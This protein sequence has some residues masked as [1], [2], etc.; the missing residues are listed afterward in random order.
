MIPEALPRISRR[1][2]L[3]SS[4]VG[5]GSLALASLVN[6]KSSAADVSNPLAITVPHIVPRAKRIIFLF[7]SANPR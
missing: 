5:F 4:A 6:S 7:M 1:A 2:M 3:E